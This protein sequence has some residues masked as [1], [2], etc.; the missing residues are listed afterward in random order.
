MNDDWQPI[1]CGESHVTLPIG[2]AVHVGPIEHTYAPY[3]VV[4][5]EGFSLDPVNH[6]DTV[7]ML[8]GHSP[9]LDEMVA[10]LEELASVGYDDH[11]PYCEQYIDEGHSH[12]C[13]LANLLKRVKGEA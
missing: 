6:D 4:L 3:S 1:D 8:R 11:C 13:R 9:L 5:G 7:R 12:Y 2:D 10:M